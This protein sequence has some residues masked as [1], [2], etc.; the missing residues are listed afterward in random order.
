MDGTPKFLDA[1][2]PKV[3]PADLSNFQSAEKSALEH[4]LMEL[5]TG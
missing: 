2:T 1:E 3:Q 4:A 5:L